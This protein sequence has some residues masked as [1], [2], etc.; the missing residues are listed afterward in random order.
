M[1]KGTYRS[2]PVKVLDW[3]R[4][5]L[6]SRGRVVVGIDVAKEQQYASFMTDRKDVLVT[7]TW[8][9]PQETPAFLSGCAKL[10][11]LGVKVEAAMEPT[12]T[13]GD[14]IR[15]GLADR[16][17]EVYRVSGKRAKDARELRDGVPSM[18]DAKATQLIGWLHLE[19]ASEPWP[20]RSEWEREV[21]AGRD[22]V[23]MQEERVQSGVNRLEAK[24]ARHWPEATQYLQLT[25][26]AL[27]A[28]LAEYGSPSA[29]ATAGPRAVKLLRR[30]GRSF[31]SE[32]KAVALVESA[33]VTQGLPLTPVERRYV[34]EVAADVLESSRARRKAEDKLVSLTRERIPPEASALVG[35]VTAA[36]LVASGLDPTMYKTAAAF[37]KACG[38]NLR[39]TSSGKQKGRLHISKRGNGDA[40]QWLYMAALRLIQAN[41]VLRAWYTRKLARD[42]GR[43]SNINAVVA[44][45]RKLTLALWNV[46]TKGEAFD[47]SKLFDVSRLVQEL[48]RNGGAKAV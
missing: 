12:G 42:G 44:I 20:L 43:V 34:Q 46:W 15:V 41:A 25:S 29:V 13:Y 24:L 23:E 9:H 35:A 5:A 37:Q 1:S 2:R 21:A 18:H 8:K 22:L 36:V 38:L 11:L 17:V 27:H 16:G 32:E 39:E 4:V 31:L 10:R 33:R 6:E 19:G 48:R 3:E 45:E 7:V 47:A 30:V 14:V 40:R 28:L 26:V